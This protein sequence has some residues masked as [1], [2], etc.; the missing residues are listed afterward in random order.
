MAVTTR[1][2]PVLVA[3][4]GPAGMSLAAEFGWRGVACLMV[5]ERDGPVDHP[6]ATLLGA[7]SMEH[8]RR[9]GLAE[10][11]IDAGLP[12]DYPIDIIFTTRLAAFEIFRFSLTTMGEF[13]SY[14]PGLAARLPDAGWSPYYKTQIGQQALEPVIGGFASSFDHVDLRYGWRF[15]GFEQDGSGVTATIREVKTGRDERI[16]AQYLVGCEGGRSVVRQL[17]GIPYTGRGAMRANV[18]FFFR[19]EK[20]LSTHSLGR[21]TLY[22]TL[23][24]GSFGVFT[25]IDGHELWNYQHYFLDPDEPADSVDPASAI[26]EGMGAEFPFEILSVTRWSHH[27]SVAGRYRDD[28]VFLA[29]DSAHLFCPTGG[30][31]MNTGIGDAVDLGW[32]LAG[33]L[34]GWG[35]DGLLDSYESER[36]PVAVRNTLDAASNADRIDA[37]MRATTAEVEADNPTGA[38]LR[39]ELCEKLQPSRKTF[40]A[41]GIHLGYRYAGSPICLPDGS[42]EPPDEPQVYHPSTWPGARAP[43]SWRA[44]GVSTLDW[45]A[46]GFTLV[47]LGGELPDLTPF[48]SE[49]RRAG[50]PLEVVRCELAEVCTLYE[51]KL[52]LVRPDG[53]VAWRGDA[54]PDEPRRV[55]DVVR[56]ASA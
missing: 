21:G 22:W 42:P 54:L 3:G 45:F 38:G 39:E 26:R 15:E 24:P 56:G 7:R 30:F 52:V 14:T 25:A 10:A 16:R 9:W 40:S 41:S 19:S 36:R 53:H 49:A 17:L 8:Y 51:R 47:A 12:L 37:V 44:P 20:F 32:K 48:E 35:R 43:H 33:T 5:E 34:A 23:A 46:R 18:S 2:V 13:M 31:G 6:R 4:G 55:L 29:G 27:Q 11:V 50:L 1:E 28:R